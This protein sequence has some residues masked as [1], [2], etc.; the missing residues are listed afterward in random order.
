M[1]NVILCG[2][3][4]SRL[5][6]VSRENLPKQ[7]LKMFDGNSLF[8]L[9]V[10]RNKNYSED[11]I[12]VSNETQYFMTVDQVKE[13]GVEN[14]TSILEPVGRNTAASIALAAFSVNKEEIIF[15]TPSD[16][17][18]ED[19]KA[20]NKVVKKA[21]QSAIDDNLVTFGI[22]P[23]APKTGYGYIEI[24]SCKDD[25]CIVK[26]FKEK[27][28]STTAEK[29]IKKGNYFWNSGM[30]MFKA[31]VYLNELKK[32]SPDIYEDAKKAFDNAQRNGYIRINKEEMLQIRD[33]SIDYA[34]MEYSKK[35]KMI[36]SDIDWKDVGDFDSLYDVFPKDKDG[37]TENDKLLS[38][39]SKNNLVFGRYK[40]Q[41][42]INNIQDMIIVDTPTALLIT[43]RGDGQ[44]IKNIV[45]ILKEKNPE[46]V[47]YGRSVYKPWGKYINL[48]DAPNFKVKIIEVNPGKRLS[49]QKHFHRSEHWVVV[50][51][52]AE[53]TKGEDTFILRPNESTYIKIGEL[54]RLSNPG[55]IPLE[56]IEVQVGEYLSED[57]IIRVEDDYDRK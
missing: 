39:N 31:G 38:I 14:Y 27:P 43:R 22:T 55:K 40:K 41:I 6:P 18:I 10:K 28:D 50:S 12:F 42:A 33:E 34:V 21:L 54:H 30:F 48:E 20:Y 35:I 56:I 13:I 19:N 17:L 1:T 23:T 4:G 37:N 3:S 15:V 11:F 53:V 5:W 51:G 8:Q 49:L 46:I 25:I 52:I 45:N 57:D 32:H 9:T 24:E 47:K 16:H 36:K 2:G 26:S 44:D 7:F 29:Y